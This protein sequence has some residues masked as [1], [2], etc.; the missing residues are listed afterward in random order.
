MSQFKSILEK[1]KLD[2]YQQSILEREACFEQEAQ[3]I[4]IWLEPELVKNS[5]D[6]SFKIKAE[7]EPRIKNAATRKYLSRILSLN[8]AESSHSV[9]EFFIAW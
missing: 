1:R 3:E 9:E 7:Q 2:S 8:G 4:W 5:L 6:Y